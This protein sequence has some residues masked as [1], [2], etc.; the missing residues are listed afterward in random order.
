MSDTTGD[1]TTSPQPAPIRPDRSG[2]RALLI[3][4]MILVISGT[5]IGAGGALLLRKPPPPPPITD[6]SPG[7]PGPGVPNFDAGPIVQH[8]T[9]EL[10]L[11]PD[12]AQ[13]VKDAYG[14]SLTAVKALRAD[15]IIKLTAEHEKL[16]A[17]M[18]KTLTDEQYARWDQ[19]F[20]AMRTRMMP[21]APPPRGFGHPHPGDDMRGP[22]GHGGPGMNHRG[23]GGGGEQDDPLHLGPGSGPDGRGGPPFD[24]EHRGPRF[25]GGQ[26]G[27]PPQGRGAGPDQPEP[28]DGP[29]PPRPATQ[30]AQ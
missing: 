29:P 1:T 26:E 7:D 11:T 12:Q 14:Q 19:R 17:A 21:D 3:W 20:E 8:M 15:M 6:G 28:R 5:G 18:K 9:R 24:P 30:P 13:Q 16:R 4:G 23:P 2:R 25:Q 22:D 27:P 10:N